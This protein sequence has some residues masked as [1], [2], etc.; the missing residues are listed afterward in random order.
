MGSSGSKQQQQ[1]LRAAGLGGAPP[2]NSKMMETAAGVELQLTD[3]CPQGSGSADYAKY[4]DF[5]NQLLTFAMGESA[6]DFAEQL[7]KKDPNNAEVMALLAETTA[8]YDATKNKMA[9]GHWCDRLDLLQRGVDVSR[10]CFNENPEY[11]PCYRSYVIC[12]TR[13]SEALYFFKSMQGVGL[14]E[15]FHAIMKRGQQGMD[16]MPE[17]AEMPNAL[18]ALCARC[19][20][21]WYDPTTLYAMYYGLPAK[22]ELQHMAIEYH[23]QACKKDPKSLEYALRL[24]QAY[25]QSGDMNSARRWYIRVRDEMPPNALHDER[26]QGV[27]HTQLSTSFVKSKW[28]VPFA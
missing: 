27:A 17:D 24:A 11:G 2:D 9:R 20:Y 15:N 5:R 16:L 10:K 6:Y 8:L 28:N 14:V 21:R 12:A 3:A 4:V 22:R 23:T 7:F 1:Q 19:V 18:G 26:W 25:F 13:E